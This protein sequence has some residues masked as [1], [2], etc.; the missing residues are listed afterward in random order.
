MTVLLFIPA[1][2]MTT[3]HLFVSFVS[4]VHQFQTYMPTPLVQR[5]YLINEFIILIQDYYWDIIMMN[6]KTTTTKHITLHANG[7]P[8]LKR[9]SSHSL[10]PQFCNDSL[11]VVWSAN[12]D[13]SALTSKASSKVNLLNDD[14]YQWNC[15]TIIVSSFGQIEQGVH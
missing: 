10:L 12:G 9:S 2:Q 8:L 13:G 11:L 1:F 3:F 6:S 4:L 15:V 5:I 7:K 14:T